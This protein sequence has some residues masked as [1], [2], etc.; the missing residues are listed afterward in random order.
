MSGTKRSK[1]STA[2]SKQKSK[3]D[4]TKASKKK[5]TKEGKK[6][7]KEE[8]FLKEAKQAIEEITS[9]LRKT[10]QVL[11][12]L[13]SVRYTNGADFN[14]ILH[15]KFRT[16]YELISMLEEFFTKLV[17]L[18]R[19]RSAFDEKL[20]QMSKIIGNLKKATNL[21][22]FQGNLQLLG[23]ALQDSE[24]IIQ[25]YDEMYNN[26]FTEQ[27]L[28]QFQLMEQLALFRE[29]NVP[30]FSE[31]FSDSIKNFLKLNNKLSNLEES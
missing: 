30:N 28:L 13:V 29:K 24:Q 10:S 23:I 19:Y 14:G 16:D 31:L 26:L 22:E 12:S 25:N 20:S 21:Q 4:K 18:L 9:V 6:K 8:Q 3:K 27:A 7:Q 15:D 5:E 1:T 11:P 17:L 2:T